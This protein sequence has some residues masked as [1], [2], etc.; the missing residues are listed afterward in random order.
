MNSLCRLTKTLE[1]DDENVDLRQLKKLDDG[2]WCELCEI[3][4]PIPVTY[5]MRIVHP[6]CG[7]SS[8]GKGFNSVGTFCEGWAG[9]C[10]EGGKGASSWYL[11][12][13]TCREKY[14][15]ANRNLSLNSRSSNASFY[16]VQKLAAIKNN[17]E[18]NSDIYT[19]MREN[20]MFLLE[21]CSSGPGDVMNAQKRSPL[22]MSVVNERHDQETQDP[23]KP[24]TSRAEAVIHSNRSSKYIQPSG[25]HGKDIPKSTPYKKYD[26]ISC[27]SPE[28]VWQIPEDFSC[29]ESLGASIANDAPYDMLTFADN[30]FDRPL[31]EISLDSVDTSNFACAFPGPVGG[32]R[33]QNFNRFHRSLSMGQGLPAQGFGLHRP[34][35]QHNPETFYDPATK[36][37]M[38]RR[39]NSTCDSDGSLLLCNPSENLRKLIP[40]EVFHT[41]SATAQHTS[42]F[43]VPI[44]SKFE[45]YHGD[46]RQHD[47]PAGASANAGE[48]ASHNDELIAKHNELVAGRQKICLMSRP[49]LAFV[50]QAH[51]LEK[52]RGAMKRN[53]RVATC[54]IYALQ[55]MNWLMRSVTQPTCL[56][57]LMWW[58]VT[59]LNPLAIGDGGEQVLEHPISSLRMCGKMSVMLTQSFHLYLQTVADLTLLLPSG[60][61]LQQLAIQC[62]G[63][64]FRQADHHFLHQ[65][66]VFG[67][68]SKILSKSDE[69]REQAEDMS[70]MMINS[71]D[72]NLGLG[73]SAAN[74]A[75]TNI[76]WL[77]DLSNMFEVTVSSRHAMAPSLTDNSTETFWES[78]E[79]DRNRSKVIEMSLNKFDYVCR[80]IFVHIDN[81]RDIQNKITNVSFFGGQ[82]LGDMVLLRSV[83][84]T[85]KTGSWISAITHGMAQSNS[86]D[87]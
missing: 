51:N 75:E 2:T 25:L 71:H 24:S 42:H 54:R 57:D 47:E 40:E 83:D 86:N 73:P 61:A 70:S 45:N 33:S 69:I 9:N 14:I 87:L 8:K 39:N 28:L 3:Y 67:N 7:K 18:I 63:I 27:H 12:C 77:E 53:L 59:S 36:V 6:G 41:L 66:H 80:S 52:L 85:S 64:K 48:N 55:A 19:T 5:H 20:A 13:D 76:Q 30:S 82:S 17:F 32:V 4:L 15:D 50:L 58:F 43:R 11:M 49:T 31:S 21:L 60:S 10:G 68:I 46:R 56:H 26:G 1:D 23:N 44:A 84:V 81:S 78:D 37:V 35:Y 74:A 79:E 38:R 72:P 29:L 34:P 62:F 16:S 22:T 65:S